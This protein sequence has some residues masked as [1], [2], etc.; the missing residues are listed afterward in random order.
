M[1]GVLIRGVRTKTCTEARPCERQREKAASSSQGKR[2]QKKSTLLTP[3]SQTSKLPNCKKINICCLS[4]L[5]CGTF[6]WQL[7]VHQY[8]WW[9]FKYMPRRKGD[10]PE[11]DQ[12]ILKVKIIL[13]A[14]ISPVFHNYWAILKNKQK[15]HFW[16]DLAQAFSQRSTTEKQWKK[17]RVLKRKRFQW[18]IMQSRLYKRGNKG[19]GIDILGQYGGVME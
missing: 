13:E 14:L 16:T 3:C 19:G 4:H 2:P 10:S 5:V 9:K 6:L 15:I 8:N 1:T 7:L 11:Q 12:V 18:Y 17:L